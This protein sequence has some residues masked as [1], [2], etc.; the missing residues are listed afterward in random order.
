MRNYEEARGK[1]SNTQL[2]KLKSAANNDTGPTLRITKKNFQDEE[3]PYDLFLTTKTA[4]KVRNAF[5]SNISADIKLS[6]AQICR[7]IQSGKFLTS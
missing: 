7:K 1:I 5:A 2:N 4:I 3:L 6:K